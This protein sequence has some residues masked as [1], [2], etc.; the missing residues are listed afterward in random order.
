M[1]LGAATPVQPMLITTRLF[2]TSAAGKPASNQEFARWARA[3]RAVTTP[4]TLRVGM[5]ESQGRT[6]TECWN[7]YT[8]EAIA[9]WVEM[10]EC[11]LEHRAWWDYFG[12]EGCAAVYDVR[13]IGAFSWWLK[14]VALS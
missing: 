2:L 11:V 14:C 3:A 9:A 5:Q 7:E 4:T 1:G 10:E 13:A 6:P 8:K 12:R